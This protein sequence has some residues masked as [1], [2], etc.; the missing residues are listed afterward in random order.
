MSSRSCQNI[1]FTMKTLL[2]LF[3]IVSSNAH[4]LSRQE[5]AELQA[6]C[7]RSHDTRFQRKAVNGTPSEFPFAVSVDVS[8][9]LTAT[10][11]SPRH[12]ILFNVLEQDPDGSWSLFG[13][14]KASGNATCEWKSNSLV[15]PEDLNDKF[16]LNFVKRQE[17]DFEISRIIVLDSCISGTF[18]ATLY[19]PMIV[20]LKKDLIFDRDHGAVCLT[21]YRDVWRTL[22]HFSVYGLGPNGKE[23]TSSEFMWKR[24]SDYRAPVFVDCAKPVN[25][26]QGLCAVSWDSENL[27]VPRIQFQGDFGGGAVTD[28]DGRTTLLGIYVEGNDKCE[29]DPRKHEEPQFIQLATFQREICWA[30]GICVNQ[31]DHEDV[32]TTTEDDIELQR[33][34]E[35]GSGEE[36]TEPSEVITAETFE[37][38]KINEPCSE[39]HVKNIHIDIHLTSDNDNDSDY[40]AEV[41]IH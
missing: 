36:T 38:L 20:E 8:G 1:I 3:L 9:I 5:N 24:C 12:V 25:E 19:K 6:T 27:K 23:L 32:S 22:D 4:R 7:G 29:K 40:S 26:S 37:K 21:N 31:E 2:L 34:T 30:T 13:E 18:V 15:L 41:E 10:V 39:P 28:I 17:E 16:T 35:E 14:I 11:I 33:F